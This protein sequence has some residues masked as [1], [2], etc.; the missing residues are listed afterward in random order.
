MYK[1]EHSYSFEIFTLK[2]FSLIWP[3]GSQRSAFDD[4]PVKIKTLQ[5][6]SERTKVNRI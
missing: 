4:F 3:L 5:D 2:H 6:G 1:F